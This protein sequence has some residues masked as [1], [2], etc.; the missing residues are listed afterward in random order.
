MTRMS[1]QVFLVLQFIG[2]GAFAALI[3]GS[4]TGTP[5]GSWNYYEQLNAG[6]G[7]STDYYA[8]TAAEYQS[9]VF[10]GYVTYNA[11]SPPSLGYW[12]G[13][14]FDSFQVF[15]TY[16]QSD[17]NMTLPVLLGGD[18]GHSLFVNHVFVG[19]G[20]YGDNGVPYTLNLQAAVPVFIEIVGYNG[21]GPWAFSLR[22]DGPN[23]TILDEVPGLTL[24]ANGS[25]S[26]VPEPSSVI[27]WAVI[28]LCSA[29][30]CSRRKAM[31][32][33]F[34]LRTN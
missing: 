34:G 10:Q 31:W 13:Q 19:G 2:G 22:T 28:G 15:S 21:P 24:N 6:H 3:P 1:L 4:F 17:T 18:D 29:W 11:G 5:V 33:G 20:G 12:F 26:A 8:T 7:S 9:V 14:G 23:G 30:R 16:I 27:L 25:F 32:S